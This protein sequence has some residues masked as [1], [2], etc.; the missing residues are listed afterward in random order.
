M[1]HFESTKDPILLKLNEPE[2]RKTEA[3]N[4]DPQALVREPPG[5]EFAGW[6]ELTAA[7]EVWRPSMLPWAM[8]IMTP[9]PVLL[10]PEVNPLAGQLCAFISQSDP[11][12]ISSASLILAGTLL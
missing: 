7:G 1:K 9:C 12:I 3:T 6:M 5:I 8:D 11:Y 2:F 10:P 4:S